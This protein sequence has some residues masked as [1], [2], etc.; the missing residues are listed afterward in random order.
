MEKAN[1]YHYMKSDLHRFT[2]LNKHALVN[3]SNRERLN[4]L[5]EDV[6]DYFYKL[7]DIICSDLESSEP[8]IVIR[9][10]DR[11][12]RLGGRLTFVDVCWEDWIEVKLTGVKMVHFWSVVL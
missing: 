3:L 2:F 12:Y 5:S 7:I 6:S 9:F 4:G 1:V 10:D 11:F 8:Y